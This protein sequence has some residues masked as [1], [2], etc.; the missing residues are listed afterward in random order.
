MN[1]FVCQKRSLANFKFG[2]HFCAFSDCQENFHALLYF[3]MIVSVSLPNAFPNSTAEH[4]YS[5]K[6]ILGRELKRVEEEILEPKPHLFAC[7][8]P[9]DTGRFFFFFFSLDN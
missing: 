9:P 1:S 5:S 4:N 3:A 7:F 8:L 6:A 2:R